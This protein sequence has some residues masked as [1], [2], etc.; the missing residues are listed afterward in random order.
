M[1]LYTEKDHP[2]VETEFSKTYKLGH[3]P[4]S[5]VIRRGIKLVKKIKRN[6]NRR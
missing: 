6:I 3:N 5:F 1:S 4:T 2:I